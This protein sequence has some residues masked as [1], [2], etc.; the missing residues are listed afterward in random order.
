MTEIILLGMKIQ[1][2]AEKLWK[3]VPSTDR[4][5]KDFKVGELE[6]IWDENVD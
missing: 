6:Q 1:K 5:V 4:V 3:E 2:Y